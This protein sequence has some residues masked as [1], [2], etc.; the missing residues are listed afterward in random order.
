MLPTDVVPYDDDLLVPAYKI[1]LEPEF[2]GEN[3]HFWGA[4]SIAIS[5]RDSVHEFPINSVDLV[6][7]QVSLT[8]VKGV[9]R[10]PELREDKENQLVWLCF[11]EPLPCGVASLNI[12][13]SGKFNE[14]L[15]GFYLSQY[16]NADGE[17]R[18]IASTQSQPADFRRWVP[19]FDQPGPTEYKVRMKLVVSADSALTV[20]S[21]AAIRKVEDKGSKTV[22]HF[23]TTNKLPTYV[24]ALAVGDLESSP[25]SKISG[26]EVRIWATPGK[27]HLMGFSLDVLEKA[28]PML[29]KFHGVKYPNRKLDLIA[30]PNFAFGAMENDGMFIF[31]EELLLVDQSKASVSQL[32]RVAEVVIHETDHTWDGN[33]ITMMDWS[34]LSL[35]ELR[36]TFMAHLVADQIFPEWGVWERFAQDRSSAMQ[37]DAL[38]STRS[39]VT[40]IN[41]I[42]ECESIVDVITY[43]KGAAV[44]RQGQMF[45]ESIVPG[46]FQSGMQHFNQLYGFGNATTAQLWDAI[47]EKTDFDFRSF[48]DTW[49]LQPGF[50]VITVLRARNGITLQQGL[51][52]YL[53]PPDGADPIWK[54]PVF[55]RH[56]KDGKATEQT[57]LLE[58]EQQTFELSDDY[59]WLVVNAGGHGFYRVVYDA[60]LRVKLKHHLNELSAVERFNYIDDAWAMLHADL[61]TDATY[62]EILSDFAG[63]TDPNVWRLIAGSVIRL[64]D[65]LPSS[66]QSTVKR[67]GVELAT[68]QLNRLGWHAKDTDTTR[69]SELRGVIIDLLGFLQVDGIKEQARKI[70]DAW[71]QDRDA[72]NADVFAASLKV[73]A[74]TGDEELHGEY[75]RELRGELTPQQVSVFLRAICCFPDNWTAAKTFAL[76]LGGVVKT[77]MGGSLLNCLLQNANVRNQTWRS[78]KTHLAELNKVL[79]T[80]LLMRALEG[81]RFLDGEADRK[82]IEAFFADNLDLLRGSERTIAQTLEWQAINS[83]FR[84]TNS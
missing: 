83:E 61:I 58:S 63:E 1:F 67:I 55:V 71:M 84:V 34:Q 40:A 60:A 4:V 39:I 20:R 16:Q 77:Q 50:P 45:L 44:L 30:V 53:A 33:R 68:S 36:A 18:Y 79:P 2:G 52:T 23:E 12:V 27:T 15:R 56:Y 37:T 32:A 13:Y 66:H 3:P 29:E 35:N 10:T 62:V 57:F 41:R 26:V 72:V 42:E 48:M 31:R 74:Y 46:G 38:A 28:L 65:V 9:R 25:V 43:E 70:Y 47:G 8:D 81:V 64:H 54:V 21:N 5:V 24:F 69:D 76:L 14:Q 7:D 19:S 80:I 78:I 73:L 17:T 59:D 82:D 22:T 11:D 51:F 49:M 75:V 6:F